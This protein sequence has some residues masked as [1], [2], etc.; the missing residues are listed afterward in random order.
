MKNLSIILLSLG[1]V[2]LGACQNQ[3]GEEPQKKSAP[4]EFSQSYK[5]PLFEEKERI[6]KIGEALSSVHRF[7]SEAA[8]AHH[9][10]GLAYGVVVDDSLVFFGAYGNSNM[11][12]GTLATEHSLFRIASMSKSF[13]AMAILKLRDEGKLSL[14]DP[15]YTYIPE[16]DHLS[17]LTRDTPPVS[18]FNLLTMTAGFPEH[19]ARAV[20][21]AALSGETWAIEIIE[22]S[23][24][25]VSDLVADLVSIFGV[26]RVAIGGSIGL[27]ETYLDR[28]V[29]YQNALPSLFQT[30]LLE[31]E[32]G[33]TG[34][35][36]GALLRATEKQQ[37]DN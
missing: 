26:S 5:P 34:P 31:A 37:I 16:L 25:A 22:T 7:Y 21:Q 1:L 11:E 32:L 12:N 10:P 27:A 33:A 17:Y 2:C 29:T 6:R 19:D 35:L 9:L 28:I 15:V 4:A 18:I 30:K 24:R 13:T 3:S 36:T 14:S 8:E 23:A 20:F